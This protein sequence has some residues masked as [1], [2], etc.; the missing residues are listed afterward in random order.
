MRHIL[1]ILLLIF[2]ALMI[3]PAAAAED[4]ETKTVPE[5]S[6]IH[7]VTL[8]PT[9][10]PTKE[11][12]PQVGWVTITST[13]SGASVSMDG[14]PIGIT[15][16]SGIE[17]GAGIA[18]SVRITLGGYEPY[19]KEIR[20][21]AGEQSALDAELKPVVTPS[22]TKEPTQEPTIP[23]QPFG[24]DKGWFRVHCNVDGATAS[25]DDRSSGCTIAQGSCSIEVTVTGTPVSTFTVQKPGYE[26]V[27]KSVPHMP[28]KGETVDL[29]ATLN[30]IPVPSYGSVSVSSYPSGSVA[31][32]D[33]QSWQYTPC[34]FSSVSAGSNHNIQISASGYQ[35]YTTTVFVSGGQISSVSANLVPN[36]P[37]PSTGSLN[38][39]TSPASADIYVDGRY[40]TQSP[41]IVPNLAPGSHSL[42]LHKAGYDEYVSTVTVYAGQMTPVTVTLSPQRST[43]GSIEVMSTPAGSAL[44][45]DGHYMGLT[46]SGDYF[47]LTSLIPGYHTILLRHADYQD[48]SQSVYVPS[49]GVATVTAKLVPVVPGPTP[50]HTGQVVL[51]SSPAGAQ[52]FLDNVY[53]GI[54]PMTLADVAVG[55]HT[56]TIRLSGYQDSVQTVT[57]NGGQSAAVAVTLVQSQP[58]ATPAPTKSPVSVLPVICAT[59]LAGIVLLAR[60]K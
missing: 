19:E 29:Y 57:V 53:K 38:V 21:S 34:T 41:G 46:P 17:I 20:V 5:P 28:G 9:A 50:D 1:V 40:I 15:P 2:A 16:L 56:L 33:G 42:R 52:V 13:P 35:T 23:P 14:K 6:I 31:T 43:V 48:Y 36:P 18:H 44:Y 11:P 47:D 25:L 4:N 60:R 45:L 24:S 55:S 37:Y 12:G 8:E 10:E 51:T 58:T 27:S 30:P 32:L 59:A 39:G 49:G 3:V 54:T 26:I 7:G 22:P